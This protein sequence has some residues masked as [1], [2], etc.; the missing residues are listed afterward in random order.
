MG[1]RFN[2]TTAGRR[3]IAGAVVGLALGGFAVL[4]LVLL[5]QVAQ[6]SDAIRQTQLD[7]TAR[8]EADSRSLALIESCALESGDCRQAAVQRSANVIEATNRFTALVVACADQ[9]GT[10][11]A[12]TI[13]ACV[14]EKIEKESSE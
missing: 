10:Q 14:Q 6:L 2:Y 12:Q 8:N 13:L 3:R 9:P 11:T 5:A 7:N 1:D 4:V